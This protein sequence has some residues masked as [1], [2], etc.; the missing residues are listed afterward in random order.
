[1]LGKQHLIVTIVFLFAYLSIIIFSYFNTAKIT[2][3]SSFFVILFSV[4]KTQYIF[5][6]LFSVGV[7]ISSTA[8]DIDMTSN[9][10]GFF[11]WNKITR[12]GYLVLTA[13]MK[14]FANKDT[15]EHRHLYHSVFGIIIYAAIIF[16]IFF[17]AGFIFLAITLLLSHQAI[18]LELFALTFNK[19]MVYKTYLYIFIIGCAVGFMSHLLEDTITVTGINYFPGI[20]KYRLAGRFITCGKHGYRKRDTGELVYVPFFKRTGFAAIL[21]SIYTF[22]FIGTFFYFNIYLSGWLYSSILFLVGY[23]IYSTIFCGLKIKKW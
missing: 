17:F 21:L 8:P 10:E 13:F 4:I 16:L 6:L 12:L 19:L 2:S 5:L 14:P 1:M 20:S 22:I 15:F 23:L 11:I 9:T 7:I 3:I 18:G